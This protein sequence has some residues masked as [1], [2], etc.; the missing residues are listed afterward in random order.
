MKKLVCKSYADP[1]LTLSQRDAGFYLLMSF[2][3]TNPSL[4]SCSGV[5]WQR[6]RY[7]VSDLDQWLAQSVIVSRP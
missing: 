7:S 1:D 5:S 6:P 3:R 4:A 2:L